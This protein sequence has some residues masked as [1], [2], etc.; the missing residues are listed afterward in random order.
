MA[1]VLAEVLV[2]SGLLVP[3]EAGLTAAEAAGLEASLVTRASR[4]G[5]G[6]VFAGPAGI[7][8]SGRL[9]TSAAA[10]MAALFPVAIAKAAGPRARSRSAMGARRNMVAH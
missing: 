9:A 10:R 8:V 1:E 6:W 3:N 2:V 5:T 7:P 4:K